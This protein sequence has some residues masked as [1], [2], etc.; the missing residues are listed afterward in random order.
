MMNP[1]SLSSKSLGLGVVLGTRNTPIQISK[2]QV[3]LIQ[4]MTRNE[5]FWLYF[6]P[7]SYT[8]MDYQV[9]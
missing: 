9:L 8:S 4:G 3:S 2:V 7:F 6:S 1:M 5:S